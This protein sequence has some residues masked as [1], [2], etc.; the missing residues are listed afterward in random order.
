MVMVVVMMMK[1]VMMIINSS[2]TGNW[3]VM[4]THMEHHFL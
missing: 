2:Y 1:M 4:G 3:R